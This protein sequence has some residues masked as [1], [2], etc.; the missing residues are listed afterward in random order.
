MILGTIIFSIHQPRYS[1][2]SLFDTLYLVAAGYCVYHG[3]AQKV[4]EFFDS[5]GYRCEEHNNPADF[6]LDVCQGDKPR[7]GAPTGKTLET[8]ADTKALALTLNEAYRKTSIYQEIENELSERCRSPKE[9]SKEDL[10]KNKSRWN[11]FLYLSQR[12]LRNTFRD[13]SLTILQTVISVIL[14]VLVGLIYLNIDR[15]LDTGVKNRNGAIFFI[16]TNQ[17]F[18]NLSALDAFIRERVLFIHEN[19]SGYYHILTFFFSKILCDILPLRTIPAILFSIIVY[20]MIG[21]Q[22]TAAKFFVF[23]FCIWLTSICST[24]LCFF[25]SASV[26]NSGS[27]DGIHLFLVINTCFLFVV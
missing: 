27:L 18:S 11:D 6:V 26:Q 16:V 21:L 5:V 12:T 22:R 8:T 3:P 13:P 4:L 15:T 1:I 2:F 10:T 14:A 25:V 20:F 23:F 24:A 7:T 19:V 17:V 9:K